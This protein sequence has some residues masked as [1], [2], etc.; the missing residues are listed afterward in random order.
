[1]NLQGRDQSRRSRRHF[2]DRKGECRLVRLRRFRGAAELSYELE[3]RRT[4]L[5]IGRRGFEVGQTLMLRH[6]KRLLVHRGAPCGNS[7]P[8][9]RSSPVVFG[10]K[11]SD[12][13]RS[14]QQG[15]EVEAWA[16]HEEDL[17]LAR[18]IFDQTVTEELLYCTSQARLPLLMARNTSSSCGLAAR[19]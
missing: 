6:M 14:W 7:S 17:M 1:M 11:P 10:P 5:G 13:R 4:Y 3:R 12:S 15:G 2:L 8:A 16:S 18:A 9:R 19:V